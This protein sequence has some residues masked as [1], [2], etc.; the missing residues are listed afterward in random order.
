MRRILLLGIALTLAA[1]GSGDPVT[2]P[3]GPSVAGSYQLTMVDGHDLPFTVVDLGTYK[4]RIV[5]GALALK[6]NGSYTFGFDLSL[7]DGVKLRPAAD[8]DA[9]RWSVS[10]NAIS[11]TSALDTF[12]RAGT[13]SGNV[14][15]LQS[16]TRVFVLRK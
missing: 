14:I 15:T 9:G 12:P 3:P 7:D 16:S 5:S 10:G 2:P 6:P 11:L 4:A 13:V 8:S 1:C